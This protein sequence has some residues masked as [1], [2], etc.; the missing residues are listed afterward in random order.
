MRRKLIAF[1][2]LFI[3]FFQLCSPIVF[4]TS[5]EENSS[6]EVN[7]M[8][9]TEIVKENSKEGQDKETTEEVKQKEEITNQDEKEQ[10]KTNKEESTKEVAEQKEQTEEQKNEAKEEEEKKENQQED[11]TTKE[12]QKTEDLENQDEKQ[13]EQIQPKQKSTV[14]SQTRGIDEEIT[15]N[16]DNFKQMI[17]EKCDKNGD[18]IITKSEM[19]Q[20][21]SLYIDSQEIED[22]TGIENAINI[23]DLEINSKKIEDFSPIKNLTNLQK[24]KINTNKNIIQYIKDFE[25]ETEINLNMGEY[26]F[27]GDEESIS[28]ELVKEILKDAEE[29]KTEK[30]YLNFINIE[31]N[32]GDVKPNTEIEIPFSDIEVYNSITNENSKF[33]GGKSWKWNEYLVDNENKKVKFTADNYIHNGI[34]TFIINSDKLNA[35]LAFKYNV[36]NEGSKT[37]EIEIPDEYFRNS[38]LELNDIDKDEKITEYDMVNI[39]TLVLYSSVKN[40]SGIENAVNIK[41]LRLYTDEMDLSP[42]EPLVNLKTLY[43]RD[44]K[45]ED[46]NMVSNYT[47]LTKLYLYGSNII[48]DCNIFSDLKNLEEIALGGVKEFK[49][50]SVFSSL[51]NLNKFTLNTSYN[52]IE[53]LKYLN[54]NVSLNLS[55]GT[56]EKNFSEE[57]ANEI[58]NEL[59]ELN[60]AECKINYFYIK[61]DLGNIDINQSNKIPLSRFNIYQQINN[62]ESILNGEIGRFIVGNANILQI[63]EDNLVL[64]K[65][66]IG[67]KVSSY[68][69]IDSSNVFTTITVEYRVTV[70]VDD[71]EEV[72]IKD[73]KL[74]EYL[75][76]NHDIDDDE[77]IT[78]VDMKNIQSL[79]VEY[80]VKDLSGLENATNLEDINL[81][82]KTID[83][84]PLKQLTKLTSLEIED[85]S[86]NIDSEYNSIDVI[87]DLTTLKTLRINGKTKD[88]NIKDWSNLQN[89][90]TLKI[91][92]YETNVNIDEDM[93]FTKLK[94]LYLYS[95]L[96]EYDCS[97][98]ENLTNLE[99]LDIRNINSI[100]NTSILNN[101]TNLKSIYLSVNKSN[102]IE[103]LKDIENKDYLNLQI[104][105]NEVIDGKEVNEFIEN[106]EEIKIENCCL[107]EARIIYDLG[108]IAPN[109]IKELDFSDIEIINKC[110]DSNSKFFFMESQEDADYF[111]GDNDIQI[112]F[113]SRK[114]NIEVGEYLGEQTKE[115][116]CYSKNNIS[117]IF[118]Y[119]VQVDGNTEEEIEIPDTN[120]KKYLLENHDFDRNEKITEI[121]MLNI[122]SITIPYEV[123]N[124]SGIEYA[125]NLKYLYINSKNNNVE[126]IKNLQ[127]LE[128]ISFSEY[129]YSDLSVFYRLN[130]LREIEIQNVSSN[131]KIS[132]LNHLEN[133]KVLKMIVSNGVTIDYS[134]IEIE[135]LEDLNINDTDLN[136]NFGNY[137]KLSKLQNLVFDN[138]KS[139]ENIEELNKLENISYITF[140][141]K[142]NVVPDLQNIKDSINVNMTFGKYYDKVTEDEAINII[143]SLENSNIQNFYVNRI[144]TK[145]TIGDIEPESKKT[146]NYTD[147]EFYNLFKN[148]SSRFHQ[149]DIYVNCDYSSITT[150]DNNKTLTINTNSYL[151]EE[152]IP[153][154]IDANRIEVEVE[155]EYNVKREGDTTEEIEIKDAEFKRKLL[156]D[157]DIDD[158]KRI[159]ENDMINIQELYIDYNIQD[160]SGIEYA[161]NLET[162]YISSIE[163]LSPIKDLKKLKKLDIYNLKMNNLSVIK[164]IDSLN[165]LHISG[166]NI[167]IDVSE[168]NSLDKLEYLSFYINE[169]GSIDFSNIYLKKLK[170]LFVNQQDLEVDFSNFVDLTNAKSFTFEGVKSFE[171][172][173]SLNE[174]EKLESISFRTNNN[175]IPQLSGISDNV[176]LYMNF[177][178]YEY[179]SKED[180][181]EIIDSINDLNK[182]NIFVNMRIEEDIG[183][184]NPNSQK[185]INFDELYLYNA[186]NDSNSVLHG[187]I[188]SMY[189]SS[190]YINLDE[191]NKKVEITTNEN[192]GI[193]T[194]SIYIYSPK[195]NAETV[196]RYSVREEADDTNE[197]EINDEEFKKYLLE[198]KDI[199]GDEKITEYDMKNITEIYLNPEINDIS[200]IEY[201]TNVKELRIFG[202]NSNRS[203]SPLRNLNKLENVYVDIYNEELNIFEGNQNLR[204]LSLSNISRNIELSYFSRF[205]NLRELRIRTQNDYSINCSNLTLSK[206]EDLE[207]S[208]DNLQ[209]NFNNFVQLQNLQYLYLNGVTEL[210]NADVLN[211]LPM[212]ENIEI[213]T[214]YNVIS[215]I[216]NL[217]E[218]INVSLEFGNKNAISETEANNIIND[219][220]KLKTNNLRIDN[221]YIEKDI[222]HVEPGK[223]TEF[224]FSDFAIYNAIMDESHKLYADNFNIEET[225]WYSGEGYTI[226]IDKDNKKI[227]VNPGEATGYVNYAFGIAT[228]NMRT[229][230]TIKTLV[231]YEG[232]NTKE[233]EIKDEDFKKYLLEECDYDED[234]KITEFDMANIISLYIYEHYTTLSGLEYATNLK[235][236][237]ISNIYYDTEIPEI[238]QLGNLEELRL[239]GSMDD[240][241]TQ[242]TNPNIQILYLEN[243]VNNGY[244][245]N[246]NFVKNMPNLKEISLIGIDNILNMEVLKSLNKLEKAK[247]YYSN[248]N[249]ISDF[250]DYN[251]EITI[252]K[253]YSFEQE[254][255]VTFIEKFNNT[256]DN[257]KLDDT[258]NLKVYLGAVNNQYTC[259]YEDLSPIFDYLNEDTKFGRLYGGERLDVNGQYY[260]MGPYECDAFDNETRKFYI[261][262]MENGEYEACARFESEKIK[263]NLQ[264]NFMV[265]SNPDEDNKIVNIPDEILKEYLVSNY[266]KDGDGELSRYEMSQIYV[267]ASYRLEDKNIKD[268][269]GLEYATNLWQLDLYGLSIENIDILDSINTSKIEDLPIDADQ[270]YEINVGKIQLNTSKQVGLPNIFEKAMDK[271]SFLYDSNY[272]LEIQSYGDF[273]IS[274]INNKKIELDTSK[275]GDYE[276]EVYIRRKDY[277]VDIENRY[278]VSGTRAVIKYKVY[279]ESDDKTEV[280]FKDSNLK[281]ELLKNYDIDEDTKITKADMINIGKLYLEGCKIS[282]LTGLEYATNC[283]YLSFYNNNISNISVLSKLP[284]LIEVNLGSNNVS[285]I[286]PLMNLSNIEWCSL[287]DNNISDITCLANRKFK[288][289]TALG[290]GNNFIDFSNNSNSLKIYLQELKKELG[291]QY[292]EREAIIASFAS[293]QRIGKKSDMNKTVVLD[294]SIKNKIISMGADTNG[295]GNLTRQE[296]YDAT[297]YTYDETTDDYIEPKV[298]ELDLSN[299]N[300]TNIS[301]I[302]YLTELRKLNL[303]NNKIKDFSPLG[304]MFNLHSL[305]L[306]NTGISDISI[307]P[308][309][310]L[311]YADKYELNLSNNSIKDISCIKD[312]IISKYTGYIG[313]QSGGDINYRIINIDLSNNKVE[314]ISVINDIHTLQYINLSNNS[315]KD[316][317]SLKNYNF[318]VNEDYWE[319]E[320]EQKEQLEIFTGINLSNNYIDVNS[321]STKASKKVFD[322][323]KVTLNLSNQKAINPFKDVKETNWYFDAVKYVYENNIIKGYSD[324]VFAPN[325]K[326]TRG[327]LVTI[328]HRMEGSPKVTGKSKFSDVQDS[329]KYYYNAVI[330]ATQNKIVSGYNNGKFGATDY[331]TREQLAV[332]LYKYA[333]YKGKNVSK[334]SDLKGFTDVDKIGSYALTQVKWAVGVGI[335]NGNTKTKTINPKG[336]AT[337]AEVATMI[338]NYCI[339]VGR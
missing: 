240:I 50:P 218:N 3:M 156:Q 144:Y 271:N 243:G 295:D 117:I 123:E 75:L 17:I 14:K 150:D 257:V 110:A 324:T 325:D 109:T 189:A 302:E 183:K 141:T 285:D 231:C 273:N 62:E 94:E 96:K 86:D 143:N 258:I 112:D 227:T 188:S 225:L 137:S 125:T 199:D 51:T 19:E 157:H 226:N 22:I 67:K 277:D 256:G 287:Y 33:Y 37:K 234:K 266:D 64:N 288:D 13:E 46:L 264:V 297:Q 265:S 148:E 74:K 202:E 31:K 127:N 279:I 164:N 89:L 147:F 182:E 136:V 294:A 253:Q 200:E 304:K 21:D 174:L 316:I 69:I 267:F 60:V 55:L 52:I 301:G 100:N 180:A 32:L 329:A 113:D 77:R 132:D 339:K 12:E 247:L 197:I 195:V 45:N 170:N 166:V 149:E 233:V 152:M 44:I 246:L 317:S 198:E 244:N 70:P 310:L 4:A 73:E 251:I 68:F 65:D 330:W 292:P 280:I 206:L 165:E 97:K 210:Q 58:I 224:N 128:K 115:I 309:Y 298:R 104:N 35:S 9:K 146:L 275:L 236:L 209:V 228:H 130:N 151:G 42:I 23:T 171:N 66:V 299:M 220:N 261:E 139:F 91:N 272:E 178:S 120:L 268:L 255:F 249:N 232:D 11:A 122:E 296:L 321:S 254:E 79:Y 116:Y 90:E 320:P 308:R 159:T 230:I 92:V 281:N 99:Y 303:E 57:E 333:K 205:E 161:T 80:D 229:N 284:K 204:T 328:L 76:E 59:N 1:F 235:R 162:L 48:V 63:D 289:V 15:F 54:N 337:R 315:I 154:R 72:E 327:M 98:F 118:E 241:K 332:I 124:L 260:S 28:S 245:F 18:N 138:I 20:I 38:L 194:S 8:E 25:D 238:N 34:K 263:I 283:I 286:S 196:L 71:N 135:N 129:N 291:N 305:N 105:L 201:A 306:K 192:L 40:I 56:S 106:Y 312:W 191:V 145:K 88:I 49:N 334:T 169:E 102:A 323:K 95:N 252:G 274:N 259:D 140:G 322:D 237:S 158:D 336:N 177:N 163:D 184:I 16:D 81:R 212:F 207:L 2:V 101:L 248:V 219:I 187:I 36:R 338:M 175:V 278:N 217:N 24:L 215:D 155:L 134:N 223:T 211:S 114:V 208:A 181:K 173:E 250:K 119:T 39:E 331:I 6:K 314:D 78:L 41:E 168:L 282:D 186:I 121:D 213:H 239:F 242:I 300:I 319:E 269:T 153:I 133:L 30:L 84:T 93:N 270:K 82:N 313:W 47:N 222:G 142:Y 221:L 10:P 190:E 335:I 43:I 27:N 108:T 29:V 160:I 176:K 7:N 131:L 111:H 5:N 185:E 290:L 307:L 203:L 61:V 276:I 193:Y 179:L 311:N 83:L 214:D 326:L 87:K 107:S 172:V 216:E 103:T 26:Y 293:D 53:S 262:N 126:P 167:N 318:V 85:Y